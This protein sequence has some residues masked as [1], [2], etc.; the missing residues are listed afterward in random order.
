MT[1]FFLFGYR[2]NHQITP[3][4]QGKVVGS[5]RLLLTKTLYAPSVAQIAEVHGVSFER[6]P[7]PRLTVGPYKLC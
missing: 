4:A 3:V 7:R 1:F 6:I 5:V 2:E